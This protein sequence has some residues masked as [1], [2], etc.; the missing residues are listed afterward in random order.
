[1]M[2]FRKSFLPAAVITIAVSFLNGQEAKL[3]RAEF[4]NSG[5]P[6]AQESFLR[7]LLLLHSFEYD[8]AAEAFRQA[9]K[10]DPAFAMAYWG[11]AMTYNHPLWFQQDQKAAVDALNRLAPNPESRLAKTADEREKDYLR[12][13]EILY[14]AG[15][16]KERDLAYAR[17]MEQLFK[18]YPEDL[19]AA[20]Y[21]ALA[22]LG[23]CHEGRDFRTYMK[24][25]AIVEEVFA[26]NPNHP[27][28]AHYLIHSYDDPVHGPLG[29]RAAR[30]YAQ[31]APAAAHAL[32]MPSHIFLAL[33]MWDE[34]VASNIDS[35]NAADARIKSKKLSIENRGYHALLW[36]EYAYLQQGRYQE[37]RKTLRIMEEDAKK[38]GSRRTRSHLAAMRAAYLI[39]TRQ[40]D[41]TIDT[42]DPS[43]L[44][45]QA[46]ATDLFAA[47]F[48]ALQKE[49]IREA[50]G[51]LAKML[52]KLPSPESSAGSHHQYTPN[53]RSVIIM[54]RQLEA[55]ILFEK[56]KRE[57]GVQRLKQA[58]EME[59]VL[60]YDF[61][62]PAPVKPSHE[63]L[64]EILLKL[65][66]AAEAKRYFTRALE[67]APRR[68]LSLL[69]LAR[70]SFKSGDSAAAE[71]AYRDLRRAWQKADPDLPEL[72]EIGQHR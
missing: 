16:K 51:I 39:E 3:G 9:Q 53:D 19:E 5:S 18:K 10:I 72:V 41:A 66:K 54:T 45:A 46:I 8:D 62:P 47:G 55:L 27:G 64:G 37:A 65:G 59:D 15:D 33:G 68:A 42:V 69:G 21:Y 2:I 30:V 22:L 38:S 36:L 24:A 4:P 17:A 12:A 57:E 58:A 70:S 7:G 26:R 1:M 34:T 31:I 23:T 67:R 29:L 40:W 50:E 6:Q 28:A 13:V 63:L 32:H 56:G 44:T 61:G 52:A 49:R 43:E 48:T 14:G 11:Q 20:S 60:A 35:W 71:A 25:A